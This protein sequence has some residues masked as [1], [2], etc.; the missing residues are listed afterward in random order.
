VLTAC[1]TSTYSCARVIARGINIAYVKITGNY[2]SK[3]Y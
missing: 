3:L 2:I 1:G